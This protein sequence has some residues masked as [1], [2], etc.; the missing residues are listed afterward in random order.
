LI[1]PGE[2]GYLYDFW[3]LNSLAHLVSLL[4]NNPQKRYQIQKNNY[5]KSKNFLWSRI[6]LNLEEIYKNLD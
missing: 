5:L 4:I 1:K 3:D 6:A 2:N